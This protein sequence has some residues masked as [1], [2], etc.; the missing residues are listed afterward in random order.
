MHTSISNSCGIVYEF[1]EKGIHRSLNEP[2]WCNSISIHICSLMPKMFNYQL[3]D[4]VLKSSISLSLWEPTRYGNLYHLS[5]ILLIVHFLSSISYNE[6]ENNCFDYVVFILNAL[7]QKYENLCYR[8]WDKVTLTEKVL[9]PNLNKTL[10][11][12]NVFKLIR[13]NGYHFTSSTTNNI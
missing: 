13:E 3:L 4:E 7:A 2:A 1:N 6:R 11:L 12:V 9:L 5:N 10:R 8:K